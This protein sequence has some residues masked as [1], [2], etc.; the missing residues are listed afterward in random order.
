MWPRPPPAPLS[1][2]QSPAWAPDRLSAAYVVMP[3]QSMGAASSLD[4]AS[5]ISVT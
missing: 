5:G 2:T 1:S 4:S 3:A